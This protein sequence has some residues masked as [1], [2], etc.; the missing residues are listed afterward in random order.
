MLSYPVQTD[1]MLV[2]PQNFILLESTIPDGGPTE[3]GRQEIAERIAFGPG[4]NAGSPPRA[5]ARILPLAADV[6]VARPRSRDAAVPSVLAQPRP[7]RAAM[8]HPARA[9]GG[10]YHR[11]D[12]TGARRLSAGAEP[13]AHPARSR[14]ARPDRAPDRQSRSAPR[15]GVDLRQGVETDRGGRADTRRR[16]TPR[17]PVA[18][19][20]ASSPNCRTCWANS[21]AAWRRWKW[22]A[23]ATPRPTSKRKFA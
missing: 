15:R 12:G 22:P 18:M 4:G 8:A 6:A 14:S 2:A 17:S 16:S 7:D 11:G 21:S 5:D 3:D 19:A 1:L 13:V 20:R 10:R 9:D 23:R